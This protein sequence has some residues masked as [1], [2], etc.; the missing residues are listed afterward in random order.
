MWHET[1]LQREPHESWTLR[2]IQEARRQ[3]LQRLR[4]SGKEQK[5]QEW[6]SAVKKSV[7]MVDRIG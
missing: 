6:K 4:L 2:E 7:D 1:L 5:V 3:M